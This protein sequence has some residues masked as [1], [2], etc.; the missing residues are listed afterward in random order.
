MKKL[1]IIAALIIQ[2]FSVT[3]QTQPEPIK[4]VW[5]TNVASEALN[6]R[7]NIKAAVD[8]C[9]QSGI[10]NIYVVTWNRSRTLY[11]SKIMKKEFGI[12]IMEKFADRDPLKEVIEEAHKQG[13]KVHAWFEFGFSS[14]YNENGGMILKKH[15]EWAAIDPEG[16]LVNKNKFDWMNA[17]DPKVQNF[18]ISLILEVVKNYDVDGIQGDDRLPAV[19]SLAGYDKYTV[20]LYKKEH[21]GQEPPKDYK[22]AAWVDWRAN[23][24]NQFMKRLHDKVKA[25]KPGVLVTMAPSIFP[26]SKEEYLQDWPTWVKNGWVDYIIP[27][28]YRY[29]IKAYS[30]TLESNIGY[31]PEDKRWMFCPGI[32][33]Q[34]DNHT[35][36]GEFL[37][38]M[39]DENR[40]LGFTGE[41]F[42]FFEG[43]KKHPDFFKT[44]KNK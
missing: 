40:K 20:A 18:M 35:P 5:L 10:N 28:V 27:Q 30:E 34:V 17:F 3:A 16:K 36:Q 14:S 22:D 6:S 31:M 13:I 42:F 1:F 33:L 8:L 24:L 2:G 19:P 44:Y 23:L 37:Q 12:P 25:A 26:W 21:N 39:I 9:V 11:P 29:N 38:Q 32:L 4:G 15:P 41:V 7:E 43:L